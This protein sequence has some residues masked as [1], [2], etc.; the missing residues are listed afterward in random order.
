MSTKSKYIE[1]PVTLDL[2]NPYQSTNLY[3][4]LVK[5]SLEDIA[6]GVIFHSHNRDYRFR[7]RG[8]AREFDVAVMPTDTNNSAYQAIVC[9]IFKTEKY[10]SA[11]LRVYFNNEDYHEVL[12]R[13]TLN[14]PKLLTE[15]KARIWESSSEYMNQV[16]L[17]LAPT[18]STYEKLFLS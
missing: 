5:Y 4:E 14:N 2:A 17:I 7:A 15:L 3:L 1:H 10:L 13:V 16:Q 18:F 12:R 9:Q 8:T 11:K 6:N